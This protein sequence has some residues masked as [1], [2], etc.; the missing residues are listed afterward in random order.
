VGLCE[1]LEMWTNGDGKFYVAGR[2]VSK[3]TGYK[4]IERA[5][6]F[7][8]LKW[9]EYMKRAH[10]AERKVEKLKRLILL[11]DDSMAHVGMNQLSISQWIEFV[12]CFPDEGEL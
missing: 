5:K 11:T 4:I 9:G 10:I 7:N 8:F 1:L 6:Q 3:D 2:D 12:R